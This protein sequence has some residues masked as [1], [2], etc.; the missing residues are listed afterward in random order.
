MRRITMRFASGCVIVGLLAIGGIVPQEE[1]L[2]AGEEQSKVGILPFADATASGNTQV[3]LA[4]GR[5]VQSEF[6]HS[7][8][9]LARVIALDGSMKPESL[10]GEKAVQLGRSEGVD[11]IVMGTVLDAAAEESRRGGWSPRVMGQGGSGHIRSVKAKVTL[12]GD[13]YSVATG[14]R[15]ASLRVTGTHTDRKFGGTVYTSIGHWNANDVSFMNS[16]LGKALQDAV[17]DLVKKVAEKAD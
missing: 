4:V 5:A 2:G 3:G 11:L 13:I 14:S 10:D 1:V 12:Q 7:T 9:L 16:P 17:A 6:T 8:N 15:V